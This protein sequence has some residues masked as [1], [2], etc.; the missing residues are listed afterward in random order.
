MLALLYACAS[1]DPDDSALTISESDADTDTDADSDTD[2]DTDADTTITDEM[3]NGSFPEKPIP[4]PEFVATSDTGE[5]RT[6]VDLVGHPTVMW[7]Y[8]AANTSG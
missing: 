4:V 2:T 3:L 1:P 6:E 7:F 5:Q 8:P